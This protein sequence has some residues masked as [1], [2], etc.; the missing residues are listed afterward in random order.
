MLAI[1]GFRRNRNQTLSTQELQESEA[2]VYED[3]AGATAP[4][5]CVL[6]ITTHTKVFLHFPCPII[7]PSSWFF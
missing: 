6:S 3:H 5:G 1:F 4:V 7:S 2:E